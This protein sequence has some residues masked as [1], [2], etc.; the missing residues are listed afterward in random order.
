M[1]L[2]LCMLFIYLFTTITES[3][4]AQGMIN[5]FL[6]HVRT[7][8]STNLDSWRLSTIIT[9]SPASIIQ[10]FANSGILDDIDDLSSETKWLS[11]FLSKYTPP[12]WL[13]VGM[14]TLFKNFLTTLIPPKLLN[15]FVLINIIPGRMD[16]VYQVLSAYKFSYGECFTTYRFC[17]GEILQL[18][19]IQFVAGFPLRYIHFSSLFSDQRI[20]M[21]VD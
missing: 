9:S 13:C 16:M 8:S 7:Q 19:A 3:S 20:F 1:H 15:S 4:A 6:G 2:C 14:G 18:P 21:P 5:D 12:L 17:L 11:W 10:T